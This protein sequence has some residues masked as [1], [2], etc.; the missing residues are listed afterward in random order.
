M[1]KRKIISR[2]LVSII[3]LAVLALALPVGVAM[4]ALLPP[5]P[6]SGPVGS[7]VTLTSD[8]GTFPASQQG[9][10]TFG[11]G[12]IASSSFLCNTDATGKLSNATFTVPPGPA[13]Q[14]FISVSVPT[15]ATPLQTAFSITPAVA[16]STTYVKVGDQLAVTGTGFTAN[17]A[18]TVRWDGTIVASASTNTYGAFG[19]VYFSVPTSTAG[20][21][22]VSAS[23]GIYAVY[24]TASIAQSV[25]VT[26]NSGSVGD[27]VTISGSAFGAYRSVTI[28]FDTTTLSTVPTTDANGSFSTTFTVPALS[29]HSVSVTANDGI[30]SATTT[31]SLVAG[32][33]VTPTSGVVG[34]SATAAGSG[35]G[36][37]RS[38]TVS[39]DSVQVAT[40][41]TD[42]SGSFSLGFSIPSATGG[43][44]SITANDGQYS[45]SGTFTVKPQV[46][47]NPNSGV[48]GKQVTMNGNGFSSGGAVTVNFDNTQAATATADANG[49]FSAS[50]AAPP[51]SGGN[52]NITASDGVNSASGQFAIAA[53]VTLSPKS[54]PTGSQVNISGSGF[55]A[56]ASVTTRFDNGQVKASTTDATG[57]FSDKF[58]VPDLDAGTYNVAASDG[59]NSATISFAITSSMRLDPSTGNVGSPLTVTGT[60]FIGTVTI[61][62]DGTTVATA[63]ADVNGAFTAAFN[64]PVSLHG[65]HTIVATDGSTTLQRS[66]TM[67]STP[68][69]TPTL[70]TPVTT[71]VQ[72]A[73]PTFTWTGVTDP[74]GVSYT[75]QVAADPSFT[76]IL[77]QK[78]GLS[79]AQYKVQGAESLK[80]TGK[81]SPYYWRVKA[82]DQA[83]NESAFS[84]P[85]IFSVSVFPAWAMWLLIAIGALI[86]LLIVLYV[87][88][89]LGRRTTD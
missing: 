1:L 14:Y 50:F 18:I 66:F 2:M 53:S 74:S 42:V 20:T 59:T 40:G 27:T 37:S 84:S 87:G 31:F 63:A 43:Q 57:S 16:V 17:Y 29:S 49:S 6:T 9:T 67:D 60:G 47:V 85:N 62:Y 72:N 5:S 86:V 46:Q 56:N 52:H 64:A 30:V 68:P 78:Q 41:T 39:L 19:P 69:P 7:V 11:A 81:D 88:V 75:L 61:K 73:R 77:L 24:T 80:A 76:V 23:D 51:S 79:A 4:A 65:N 58:V 33:R 25:K 28:T 3:T 36:S 82:V 21:H 55:R 38:L 35:F 15:G 8:A 22:S 45:A 32:I 54:G 13:A 10:I 12:T 70:L 83:S 34:S 89:R 71:S 26:P 44:H 48:V